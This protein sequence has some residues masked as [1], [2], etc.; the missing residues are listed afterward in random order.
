MC[1]PEINGQLSTN[2]S[3]TST[4]PAFS[5]WLVASAESTGF[6]ID[7]YGKPKEQKHIMKPKRHIS[8]RTLDF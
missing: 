5:C 4:P 2:L 6:H 1:S 3:H 7:L 8:S